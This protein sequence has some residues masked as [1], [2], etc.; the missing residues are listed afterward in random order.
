MLW[1]WISMEA[2]NSPISNI[3]LNKICASHHL[4]HERTHDEYQKKW[5]NY[6]CRDVLVSYNSSTLNSACSFN[7]SLSPSILCNTRLK[8][9][10]ISRPTHIT[11]LQHNDYGV[12]L[13]FLWPPSSSVF[14]LIILTLSLLVAE[15]STALGIN[16]SPLSAARS[17]AVKRGDVLTADIM[18]CFTNYDTT[19]WLGILWLWWFLAGVV[20]FTVIPAIHLWKQKTY[21]KKKSS[22]MLWILYYIIL[23]K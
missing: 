16:C 20:L 14:F 4:K 9:T 1:H 12:R 3:H 13:P 19:L 18:L 17:S 15:V 22:I 23:L 6:A 2:L 5:S 7:P 11:S 10:N 21:N 8:S